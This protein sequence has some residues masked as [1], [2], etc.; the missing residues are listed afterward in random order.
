[1]LHFASTV[2]QMPGIAAV[3]YWRGVGHVPSMNGY[4]MALFMWW[5][6]PQGHIYFE[7]FRQDDSRGRGLG[8]ISLRTR[9]PEDWRKIRVV[10]WLPEDDADYVAQ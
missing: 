8:G 4:M 2:L 9:H 10:L 3:M 6:D 7:D 1:M 5:R